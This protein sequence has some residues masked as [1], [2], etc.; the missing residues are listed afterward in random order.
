M[1]NSV[2]I[3][4]AARPQRTHFLAWALQGAAAA[5]FI[6]AGG[7]KLA[8]VRQMVDI[9]EQIGVG[10]WFR[11]LTGALEITGALLILTPR[12]AFWGALLLVCVMTGAV[13]THLAII[14]GNPVPAMVLLAITGS[15]AVLRRPG[16]LPR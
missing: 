7:A 1:T 16:T 3:L 14:G 8:G 13:V 2:Q 11:Y 15:V 6:A 5:A 9:F 10:Q 4:E 12:S